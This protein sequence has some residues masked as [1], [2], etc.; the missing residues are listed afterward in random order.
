MGL[1]FA[2]ITRLGKAICRCTKTF[3][4]S[5]PVPLGS[6]MIALPELCHT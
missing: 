5:R 6:F 2:D 3:P 1:I 4:Q